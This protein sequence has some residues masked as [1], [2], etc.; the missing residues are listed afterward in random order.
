MKKII[1]SFILLVVASQILFSLF[2][3]ENENETERF[4]RISHWVEKIFGYRLNIKDSYDDFHI[5]LESLNTG[6]INNLVD[7][8]FG[9][10]Q[11]LPILVQSFYQSS[12]E[13]LTIIEQPELHLHP[14]AQVGLADLFVEAIKAVDNNYFMIET[15]SEG[16]LLRLRRFIVEGKLSKND[17]VLYYTEKNIKTG[18]CEVQK[19]DI[20]EIT[21]RIANWPEG[22]F[23]QSFN[24]VRAIEKA[25]TKV[26]G[27]NSFLI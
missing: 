26:F 3:S 13:N 10:S 20:D 17:I 8:G 4:N 19:L 24:E 11:L 27:K 2:K 6:K 1:V 7:V 12:N 18:N 23:S 9:I 25:A 5:E 15:H 22:F 16:F 21:G 14:E